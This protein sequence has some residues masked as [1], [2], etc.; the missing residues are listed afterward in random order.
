MSHL[1]IH[2]VATVKKSLSSLIKILEK[3]PAFINEEDISEETIL[4]ARLSDDMFPLTKQIQITS[5][6][7][8]GMV[9][10]L[11]NS[12]NP[13]MI[14]DEK[15]VDELIQRL[16]KTLEYM[17]S[18]P[19]S[20]YDNFENTRAIFP[21]MPGKFLEAMDYIVE[22][23]VP[24]FYFHYVTTYAILRNKGMKLGKFDYLGGLSV[25]DL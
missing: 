2:T 8:K 22:Y 13:S 14:D 16:Q 19:D 20:A 9:A 12:Q 3:V 25:K 10:R 17:N 23:A 4:S 21:H 1:A 15:T 18:I 6:N 5:D 24:N 11:S 7:A